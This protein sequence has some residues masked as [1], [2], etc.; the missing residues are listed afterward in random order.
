[1]T[2]VPINKRYNGNITEPVWLA[3][4]T[5]GGLVLLIACV[6][7]ANLL[8]M[9]STERARE[10]A[11][12]GS[13]G[14]NRR[15]IVRQLLLESALLAVLDGLARPHAFVRWPSSRLDLRAAG[16]LA[17]LD[18]LHDRSPRLCVSADDLSGNDLCLRP[19]SRHP[20]IRL[21]VDIR[22]DQ[23]VQNATSSVTDRMSSASWRA[24][25]S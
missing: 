2:V 14:A 16:R 13:L 11:I 17:V 1:M 15:R 6:N 25:V 18:G 10:I 9:R 21:I 4:V 22:D 7:V 20:F 19:G 23:G 5:A 12:R 3:F 24:A 8:L